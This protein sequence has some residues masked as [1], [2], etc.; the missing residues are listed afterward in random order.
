MP[1][2]VHTERI[3]LKQ[4]LL[5]AHD[6][7]ERKVFLRTKELVV[8]NEQILKEIE[9]RKEVEADVRQALKTFLATPIKKRE[10]LDDCVL[11]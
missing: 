10:L 3:R 4:Q 6:E 8:A 9:E 1:N 5:D 7:L 11:T 2:S